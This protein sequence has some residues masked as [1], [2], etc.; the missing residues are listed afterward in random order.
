MNTLYIL[1]HGQSEWNV[2]GRIQG[3]MDSP[4]TELGKQQADTHGK[5]LKSL[6]GID[7]LFVSP[8]GRARETAF[9]VNSYAKAVV[10]FES[11]LME[12]D[13]GE[14]SGQVLSDVEARYPQAWRARTDDPFQHRPPGGENLSDMQ[15]RVSTLLQSLYAIDCDVVG[16]ITHGVMSRVILMDLLGLNPLEAVRAYHPNDAFYRLSFHAT[17]IETH[18]FKDGSG[19][20]AG[21]LRHTQAE[22][23]AR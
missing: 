6:G 21:L 4:L 3:H 9:I 19:P 22:T 2:E 5:T 11:S 10:T 14:W 13:C 20:R 7:Q 18:Y 1:R 23:I 15:E 16:L 12:R 17:E 8:S